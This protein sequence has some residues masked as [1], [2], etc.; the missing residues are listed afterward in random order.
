MRQRISC[1]VIAVCLALLTGCSS[2]APAPA[3]PAA[4][5]ARVEASLGDLLT[6][7]RAELAKLCDEL[8]D[9]VRFQERSL[10]ERRQELAL[11][12]H[13][14]LPLVVPVWREAKFSAALGISLPPYAAEDTKD[15]V[16]ARH[17]ARYGDGDAA[18]KLMKPGE[19]SQVEAP[20]YERNYP[21]EWTRLVALML[22]EAQVQAAGGDQA[23]TARV[24][25]LHSQLR[26][27]LDSKAAAG[28]LGAALLPRGR[29]VLVEAAAAWR[30]QQREANA[31]ECE[32]AVSAWGTVPAWTS[33]LQPGASRA[34]GDK[35][36]GIQGQGRATAATDLV[37]AFD[38]L[39]L[40]FPHEGARAVVAFF[41]PQDR[42]TMAQVTYRDGMGE[43]YPRPDQLAH[44]LEEDVAGKDSG[45]VHGVT[46]WS[47]GAPPLAWEVLTITPR[48]GV[49]AVVRWG[50]T[51]EAKGHSL[52]RA[53][54][55]VHLDRSFEQHRVRLAPSQ[56]GEALTLKHPKAL[57]QLGN[58]V[59]A[60]QPRQAVLHRPKEHD[61]TERLVVEYEVA[62]RT[63]PDLHQLALPLWTAFGPGQI[64]VESG[65]SHDACLALVWR[66]EHTV[67]TLRLTHASGA[68]TWEAFDA[69]PASRRDERLAQTRAFDERERTARLKAGSAQT[70]IPRTRERLE[71][72]MSRAQVQK[73]LPIGQAVHKRD[74]PHGLLV[75]TTAEPAP[76]AAAVLRE[77]VARFD[78]HD[79][80]AEL[81]ARYVDGP[82]ARAGKGQ[83]PLTE[84]T[85]RCGASQT[86]LESGGSVW[87]DLSPARKPSVLHRWEDDLT[88][89]TCTRAGGV[90]EVVLRDQKSGG[91]LPPVE[92]LPRGP[93]GCVLGVGR[94]DLLRQWNVTN[95]S[96]LADG[97]LVLTPQTP[98]PYD[99]LLVWFENDRVARI[100]ARHDAAGRG[101]APAQLAQAVS[102]AW[103]RELR[104]LGWPAR[105]DATPQGTLQGLG[106]NDTRTRVRTFWQ[107]QDDGPP[108]VYTEWKSL[109]SS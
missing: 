17:L 1:P 47:R 60:V 15:A 103:G 12:A 96:P 46:R 89:Q 78:T 70:R 31:V 102:E 24:I 65:A 20:R 4:A 33:P 99:A 77:L 35:L 9:R 48:I 14:R 69:R 6:L 40:P 44:Y 98:R 59:G 106:W 36:L 82:A 13:F 81:R 39:D 91:T 10:R 85:R 92:Y 21:V 76:Q 42:F 94:D 38:L 34:D 23:G 62:E 43:L 16:L 73:L 11:L 37:R 88:L 66:D 45:Q 18:R 29:R 57:A 19:L 100:V 86:G 52:P 22:H 105:Q 80:L 2:R 107:D 3:P 30:K 63:T 108:R 51:A 27:A 50:D 28:P 95:P 71:L 109:G 54:G 84:L 25:T 32:K 5:P 55:A 26:D 93:V 104:S 41:D 79:R 68:V 90:T 101:T 58:P 49:G 87:S 83:D 56:R 75:T 7:P 64:V 61:M 97:A 67:C 72:G 74:I 53:F 8:H